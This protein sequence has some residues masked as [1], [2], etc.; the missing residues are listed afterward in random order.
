[1]VLTRNV[2]VP[3]AASR[4]TIVPASTSR[5][6][7]AYLT[8]SSDRCLHTDDHV[9]SGQSGGQRDGGKKREEHTPRPHSGHHPVYLRDQSAGVADGVQPVCDVCAC[10]HVYVAPWYVTSVPAAYCTG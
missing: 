7:F 9:A 4:S 10:R 3:A 5:D 8:G 6:F 2:A 1:M